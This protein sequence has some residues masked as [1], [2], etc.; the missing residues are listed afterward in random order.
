VCKTREANQDGGGAS[1][2]KFNVQCKKA[3]KGGGNNEERLRKTNEVAERKVHFSS[4]EKTSRDDKGSGSARHVAKMTR[5][6][7]RRIFNISAS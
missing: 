4:W 2:S 7:R 3:R 5:R 1:L 6:M